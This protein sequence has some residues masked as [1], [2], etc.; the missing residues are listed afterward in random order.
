LHEIGKT[1]QTG[2]FDVGRERGEVSICPL[3]L[4]GRLRAGSIA[5]GLLVVAITKTAF[6]SLPSADGKG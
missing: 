4:P 2:D 1:E 5:S 3:Y 6:L